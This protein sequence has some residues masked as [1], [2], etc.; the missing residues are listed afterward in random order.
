MRV[1]YDG[2][3]LRGRRAFLRVL[4][5]T[6]AGC[7]I[8]WPDRRAFAFPGSRPGA[9]QDR[10]SEFV[11]AQLRYRGGNWNPAPSAWTSLRREVEASTS[12]NVRPQQIVLELGSEDLFSHPFLFMTGDSKFQEFQD[13]EVE[14]LVKYLRSGGLLFADDYAAVPGFGFDAAFRSAMER[15]F[16]GEP[17]QRLTADHTVFR[18]FY[19]VK[20]MGGRRVVSPFLEGITL[21]GRTAVVY[22]PNSLSGAWARDEKG[23][24]QHATEPGGDRQRKLAFHLGVNIIMYALCDDYKQDRIHLPFLR[25]KI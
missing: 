15:A 12:I 13:D 4:A 21:G 6:L 20:G 3:A 16:P 22:S 2:G 25:Q 19:L 23:R 9:S 18:S 11:F 17:L 1:Q 14:K 24:W 10:G 8:P 5:A 7:A